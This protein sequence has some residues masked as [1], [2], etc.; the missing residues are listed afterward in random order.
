[1]SLASDYA[2][3]AAALQAPEPFVVPRM[4]A[5]VIESGECRITVDG[6]HE[7]AAPPVA[8]LAFAQW[9]NATFGG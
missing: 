6:S 5:E 7:F 3:A 9:I 4:V 2:A 8:L 1:M